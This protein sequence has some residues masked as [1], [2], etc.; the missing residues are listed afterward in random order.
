LTPLLE[1]RG[2]KARTL[3]IFGDIR[4]FVGELNE[5]LAA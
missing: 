3:K 4:Q 5:A 1:M 2:G